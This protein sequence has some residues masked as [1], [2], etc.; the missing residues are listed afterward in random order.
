M[1]SGWRSVA[2]LI[3]WS[4]LADLPDFAF[5]RSS[6]GSASPLK[7]PLVLAFVSL[8]GLLFHL[9]L[10]RFEMLDGDEVMG[11]THGFFGLDQGV[12]VQ[13]ATG[14]DGKIQHDA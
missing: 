9:R 12:E 6:G 13:D 3:V 14:S 11:A 7:P 4:I 2:W 1:A 10:Y 5:A 8:D